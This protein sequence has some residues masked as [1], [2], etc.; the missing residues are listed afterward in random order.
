MGFLEH[1]EELRKRLFKILY[2]FGPVLLFVTTFEVR[3][4]WLPTPIPWLAVPIPYAI[5]FTYLSGLASQFFRLM[6]KDLVPPWVNMTIS[7]PGQAMSVQFKVGAFLALVLTMPWIAYQLWAFVSPALYHRERAL[8]A[9]I[10]IPATVLFVA[11]ALF[12]YK[13]ILPFAIPFLYGLGQGL[14]ANLFILTTDDFLD[15]VLIIMA[16]MGAAFQTPLVMWGLTAIGLVGP[17]V[18]RRYWR[19]AVIAFFVFGAVV[20][21]D[22]SGVTMV[23]V[24]LPMTFLYV[25]GMALASRTAR[26]R[27]VQ[28]LRI[29]HRTVAVVLGALLFTGS[30]GYWYY[31]TALAPPREVSL[32]AGTVDLEVPIMTLYFLPRPTN[33]TT[34]TRVSFTGA[35]TMTFRWANSTA[36]GMPVRFILSP[37]GPFEAGVLPNA[38]LYRPAG[39]NRTA[40]ALSL[41]TANGSPVVYIRSWRLDYTVRVVS[42]S[43]SYRS[44][45]WLEVDYTLR[46][47]DGFPHARSL[48]WRDLPALEQ[49]ARPAQVGSSVTLVGDLHYHRSLADFPPPTAPFRGPGSPVALQ[50]GQ[51]GNLTMELRSEFS[52]GKGDAYDMFMDGKGTLSETLDW[53]WDPAF[54]S[55]LAR[56]R[57]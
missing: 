50:A 47:I 30:F 26:R 41:S 37:S 24:A 7:S 8:V 14:G 20:T 4:H 31:S 12:A 16:A 19:F 35:S 21:P 49:S 51:L 11:G 57:A 25:G 32:A 56:V 15:M 40:S 17:S 22:G 36:G 28:A 45:S 5:N 6:V 43:Q 48:P 1:L 9:R 18:W 55:L 52:W 46:Q 29:G 27:E 33:A 38:F 3:F 39:T 34:L 23:L 2:V 44:E 53:Y 13:I 42:V 54:G 10:I